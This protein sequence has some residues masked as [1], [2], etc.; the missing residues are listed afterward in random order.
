[1]NSNIWSNSSNLVVLGIICG[2]TGYLW[3]WYLFQFAGSRA[4][5]PIQAIVLGGLPA[6]SSTCLS[7]HGTL[8]QQT[9]PFRDRE[10]QGVPVGQ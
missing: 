5:G 2:L 1:M 8:L 10:S 7:E 9:V 6:Q 3:F 4:E